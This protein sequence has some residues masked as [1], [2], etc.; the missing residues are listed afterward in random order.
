MNRSCASSSPTRCRPTRRSAC[1]GHGATA[2]AQMHAVAAL[3]RRRER[4][5]GPALRRPRLSLGPRLLRLGDRVVRTAGTPLAQAQLD[6]LPP[7]TWRSL[8]GRGLPQFAAEALRRCGVLRRLAAVRARRR[9]R[10]VGDRLDRARRGV[11]PSR[12]GGRPRR[13]RSGLRRHP[14]GRRSRLG[15]RD[16]LPRTTRRPEW[17]VGRRVRRV[18]ALSVAR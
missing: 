1:C 10:C 7:P 2:I 14:G 4:R 3:A 11:D 13:R 18:R 15:E 6:D 16:G 8:V 5:S 17:V 12:P 9:H